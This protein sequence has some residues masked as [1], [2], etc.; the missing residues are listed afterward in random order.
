MIY[1][2]LPKNN[3]QTYKSIFTTL[4]DEPPN[5]LISNSL[6]YYLSDIKMKINDYEKEW[7]IFKKHTNPYEYIHTM[8]PNKKKYISKCK[9]LSRS[10]FKMIEI[11]HTF[12]LNDIFDNIKSFHLAECQFTKF[13]PNSV[14]QR[15]YSA[16]PVL[17]QNALAPDYP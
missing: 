17:F 4:S 16:K 6:S 14:D 3:I 10:Y 7:D 2:L 5:P 13:Q 9:P 15:N 11:V 1:F 12:R 8:I